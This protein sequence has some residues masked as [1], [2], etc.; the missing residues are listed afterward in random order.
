MMMMKMVNVKT[1]RNKDP[2][3][4]LLSLL[5][6]HNLQNQVCSIKIAGIDI[7][8]YVVGNLLL[9]HTLV[10]YS[11][12]TLENCFV[13]LCTGPLATLLNIPKSQPDLV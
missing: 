8:D 9:F 13:F 1:R 2:G 6:Q 11:I 12:P 4:L 7:N 5:P 3:R 10:L